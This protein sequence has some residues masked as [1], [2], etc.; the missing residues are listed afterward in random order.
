VPAAEIPS[1]DRERT[2]WLDE[3]WLRVDYWVAESCD[4]A[5][6]AS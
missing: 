2:K 4:G 1:G 6:H 3:Q 5:T